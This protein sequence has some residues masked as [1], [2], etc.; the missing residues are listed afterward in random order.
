MQFRLLQVRLELDFTDLTYLNKIRNDKKVNDFKDWERDHTKLELVYK[1][2]PIEHT[3][4]KDPDSD[5]LVAQFY[6]KDYF[7]LTYKDY[8]KIKRQYVRLLSFVN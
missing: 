1:K 2:I 4:Y 8:L 7:K 5:K 3:I 6:N